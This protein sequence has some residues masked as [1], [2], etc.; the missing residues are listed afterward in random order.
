MMLL[1]LLLPVCLFGWAVATALSNP[2]E[3]TRRTVVAQT[4]LPGI[5]QVDG[6]LKPST[7]VLPPL[8]VPHARPIT[9]DELQAE[10]RREVALE[11]MLKFAADQGPPRQIAV[12]KRDVATNLFLVEA[13]VGC[14]RIPHA[15][16]AVYGYVFTSPALHFEVDNL[17]ALRRTSRLGQTCRRVR[18]V[19]TK[20]QGV[21]VAGGNATAILRGRYEIRRGSGW[22]G[23][24]RTWRV[25]ARYASGRWKMATV[26]EDEPDVK[27]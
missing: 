7:R 15:A 13:A 12:V 1:R 21:H 17:A 19:I 22:K 3:S 16:L 27:D 23:D 26:A 18:L 24:R 20:W 9:R 5:G 25:A 2:G 4:V 8:K 14:D 11:S 10:Q 6:Y